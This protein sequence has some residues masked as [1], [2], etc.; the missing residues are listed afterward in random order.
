MSE[1]DLSRFPRDVQLLLKAGGVKRVTKYAGRLRD[2]P[3]SH[4]ETVKKTS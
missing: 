4:R 2:R 3:Q 1:R